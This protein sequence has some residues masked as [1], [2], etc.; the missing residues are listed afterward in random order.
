MYL[1]KHL[2]PIAGRPILHHLLYQI[3]KECLEQC[4]IVVNHDDC[5]VTLDSLV[6]STQNNGEEDND[7]LGATI[8]QQ[9]QQSQQSQQPK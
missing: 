3:Q 6:T 7:S 5:G 1:P 4:I 8:I 2:L 9:P